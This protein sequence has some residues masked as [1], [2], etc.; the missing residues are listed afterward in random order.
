MPFR[1]PSL[2]PASVWG[3]WGLACA[4][5]RG[6]RGWARPGG[7]SDREVGLEAT[8]LSGEGVLWT[9]KGE[10]AVASLVVGLCDGKWGGSGKES[11]LCKWGEEENLREFVTADRGCCQ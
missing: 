9:G 1:R 10:W 3:L 4:L 2:L 5:L 7:G 6:G 11:R 8:F